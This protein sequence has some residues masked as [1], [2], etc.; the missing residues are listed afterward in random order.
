MPVLRVMIRDEE[1]LVWHIK[2]VETVGI[3]TKSFALTFARRSGAARRVILDRYWEAY[4][5]SFVRVMASAAT[6]GRLGDAVGFIPEDFWYD[7]DFEHLSYAE[8]LF[9]SP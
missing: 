2:S 3:F 1:G 5:E 7:L 4:D 9:K 8:S 6:A